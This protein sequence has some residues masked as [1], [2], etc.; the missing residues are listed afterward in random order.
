MAAPSWESCTPMIQIIIHV[1]SCSIYGCKRVIAT[2]YCPFQVGV[3]L[4][5]LGRADHGRVR[6]VRCLLAS[7]LALFYFILYL[8]SLFLLNRED[9]EG[10]SP[11][12]SLIKVRVDTLIR[13]ALVWRLCI[14]I[15]DCTSSRNS[16]LT[17]LQC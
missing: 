17:A 11:R 2:D 7:I 16:S 8:F 10:R 1:A 14:V 5:L 9:N 6:C 12:Q 15:C 3:P 13:V 4:H